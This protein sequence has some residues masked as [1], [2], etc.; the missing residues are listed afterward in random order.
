M[1][2]HFVV[3]ALSED[4]ERSIIIRMKGRVINRERKREA[5]RITLAWE[6]GAAKWTLGPFNNYFTVS[7]IS[8]QNTC[9]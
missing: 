3:R 6:T 7:G 1:E 8:Q 9:F 5:Q 2:R 4:C